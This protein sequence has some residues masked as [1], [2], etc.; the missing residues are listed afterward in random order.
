MSQWKF[1]FE[2]LFCYPGSARPKTSMSHTKY[3]RGSRASTAK[4]KFIV[5]AVSAPAKTR[6]QPRV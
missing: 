2:I 3:G 4:P 1:Q 6:T 5:R